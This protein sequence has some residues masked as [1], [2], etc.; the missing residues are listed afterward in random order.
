MRHSI[1]NTVKRNL[2]ISLSEQTDVNWVFLFIYSPKYHFSVLAIIMYMH[3]GI[4]YKEFNIGD[5][6]RK[7]DHF[8]RAVFVLIVGGGGLTIGME[9]ID[10]HR[11]WGQIDDRHGEDWQSTLCVNHQ[12]RGRGKTIDMERIDS[13]HFIVRINRLSLIL[14]GCGLYSPTI[15]MESTGL[16]IV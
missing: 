4:T 10:D 9:Q 12:F 7:R 13:Q 8:A 6:A 5:G 14:L 1:H 15:S 11:S 2:F 3:I 16:D